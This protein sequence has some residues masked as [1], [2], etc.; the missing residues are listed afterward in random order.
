[1]ILNGLRLRWLGTQELTWR[2]LIVIV[3]NSPEIRTAVVG[4]D[5]AWGLREQLL[6][7]LF[8]LLNVA[9]WQRGGDD[10][11]PRPEPLKRPG[12]ASANTGETLAHGKA[13]SIEEMNARLGW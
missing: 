10:S 8:D 1:M 2:D 3:R 6:A 11:K 5:D 12:V 13:V 7:G 9:N 4:E